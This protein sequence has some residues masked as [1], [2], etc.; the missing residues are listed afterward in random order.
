VLRRAI[1]LGSLALVV[2]SFGRAAAQP[3]R[4][5]NFVF[6]LT[7][8]QPVGTVGGMRN[9]SA[10]MAN[11][12]AFEDAIISNPLCCP[13]R[14]TILTGLYS[15]D[16]GVYTNGGGDPFGGYPAFAAHDDQ[17]RTFALALHDAGYDV[18]LFGKYLNHY[19][20]SPQPGWDAFDSF[21]G[22]NG[23]YYNYD[24]TTDFG[25]PV[26]HGSDAADYST[27]VAGS[28]ANDWLA[29]RNPTQPFFL[30]FS[31]FGPH[32]PITPA[33]QDVGATTSTSFATAAYNEAD[34]SDKP[35][36]IQ[37]RGLYGSSEATKLG[38]RWDDQYATLLS[39]DRW[40]GAFR[41]RSEEHTSELQ[42][43]A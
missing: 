23:S 39:I 6:I 17:D 28:A 41:D 36:Y 25:A 32:A 21:V 11:G 42:S 19:D 1:A 4:R 2:L 10:I 9:V 31:P 12:T 20:G 40:V 33:P 30:Y 26:F 43:H 35:S 15:H 22:S 24:W 8:D 18:G 37:A 16:N 7:D 5:P 34:V 38:T 13:S 27:D 3:T 29:S 14:A